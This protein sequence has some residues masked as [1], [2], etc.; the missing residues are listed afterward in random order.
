MEGA[1]ARDLQ[2][3]I[4]VVQG[5][6]IW[7]RSNCNPWGERMKALKILFIVALVVSGWQWWKNR[8][9]DVKPSASG[10]VPVVM[11]NGT[12]ANTVVIL[13]P[14]NCPSDAAQRADA[15]S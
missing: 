13:A 7:R 10:F 6:H 4:L 11:P 8:A 3:G 12:D 15:L 2:Q 5:E 9:D 1:D 14:L